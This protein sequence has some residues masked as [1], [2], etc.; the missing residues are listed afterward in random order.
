MRATLI[1][2]SLRA[3]APRALP[4][5]TAAPTLARSLHATARRLASEDP[6]AT[7]PRIIEL[8][9][10]IQGHEGAKAAIMKLGELMQSKGE[11]SG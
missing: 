2:R 9:N 8:R 11:S 7:D 4:R 3:A 10:K 1:T 5:A 6:L